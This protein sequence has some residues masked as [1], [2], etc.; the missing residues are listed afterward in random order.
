MKWYLARNWT[1]TAHVTPAPLVFQSP[2]LW[3]TS[4]PADLLMLLI[5]NPEFGQKYFVIRQNK[6][7]TSIILFYIFCLFQPFPTYVR[8]HVWFVLQIESFAYY[9]G[10]CQK[11]FS[12]FC[13]LRGG[14]YPPCPLRK[15]TFFFHTDFPLRGGVPPNSVKEKIR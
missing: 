4:S 14:G 6:Y 3:S 1:R 10:S 15:K 7:C 2:A 13:P 5:W 9:K 12:G 11:R 8:F